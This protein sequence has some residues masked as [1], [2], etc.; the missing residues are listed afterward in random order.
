MRYLASAQTPPV[1]SWKLPTP[2][3]GAAYDPARVA[4]LGEELERLARQRQAELAAAYRSLRPALA[5]PP[6]LTGEQERRRDRELFVVL[7]VLAALAALVP[8]L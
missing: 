6:Q 1:R 7:L 8:L 2:P 4:G 3:S 5:A